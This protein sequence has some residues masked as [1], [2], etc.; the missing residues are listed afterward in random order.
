MIRRQTEVQAFLRRDLAIVLVQF[1]M[2]IRHSGVIGT[3]TAL[4][5][6]P[7]PNNVIPS[8]DWVFHWGDGEAVRIL[9]S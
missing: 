3:P 2:R 4:R 6:K 9:V 7:F 1:C 8:E 5:A